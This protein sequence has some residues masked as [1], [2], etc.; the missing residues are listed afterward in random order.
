MECF[1][2]VAVCSSLPVKGVDFIIGNDLAGGTVMPVIEVVDEPDEFCESRVFPE[3]Y[4][5]VFRACAITR[6]QF[7]RIGDVVDLSNSFVSA[8]IL[9]YITGCES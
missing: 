7:C 5:D 4:P 8:V 2:K 6:A 3:N 9:W 1:V